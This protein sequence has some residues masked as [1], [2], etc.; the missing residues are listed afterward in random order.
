MKKVFF[1]YTWIA[2][3]LIFLGFYVFYE[4][5]KEPTKP[6]LITV[7]VKGAV[8]FEGK[9]TL[10][11]HAT[12]GELL[13]YAIVLEEADIVSLNLEE[14]LNQD[15]TYIV[16]T[17]LKVSKLNINVATHEQLI[18]IN[19]IGSVLASNIIEYRIKNGPYQ[20]I[21]DLTKVTGIGEVIYEKIRDYL[22]I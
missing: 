21:A 18:T 22:T 2:A 17:N 5:K 12:L 4:D 10:S 15:K 20:N 6:T 16:P 11:H 19:G 3:L 8:L 14:R 7:Y 1:I 13:S 9:Y